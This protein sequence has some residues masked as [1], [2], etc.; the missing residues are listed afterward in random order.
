VIAPRPIGPP[1]DRIDPPRALDEAE[2]RRLLGTASMGRISFTDHAL[3][4]IVPVPFAL[5]EEQVLIPAE[6][7]SP[8]VAAVRGAV[9]AFGVDSYDSRTETGWSVAVIGPSR[10]LGDPGQF[11]AARGIDLPW[12]WA[13]PGRCL[14]AVRLGL[15]R[16]WLSGDRNRGVLYHPQVP[17]AW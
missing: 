12:R 2:C 5:H 10:V 16:G 6:H 15:L 17:S 8:M 1:V 7:A 14:I 9:V 11:V 13:E 3:P 4:A